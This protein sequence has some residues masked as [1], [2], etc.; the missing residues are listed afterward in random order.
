MR[1][2]GMKTKL[3]EQWSALG[4][5]LFLLSLGGCAASTPPI[6]TATTAKPDTQ[7]EKQKELSQMEKAGQRD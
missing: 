3:I 7:S 4:A 2:P 6:G 5:A 1:D